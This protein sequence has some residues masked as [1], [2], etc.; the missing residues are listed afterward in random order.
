MP[1]PV[2]SRRELLARIGGHLVGV[3]VANVAAPVLDFFGT[4]PT[5]NVNTAV[6]G[7]HFGHAQAVKML[8]TERPCPGW[9]YI[10]C[11]C[12]CYA[13]ASMDA[14]DDERIAWSCWGGLQDELFQTGWAQ[15]YR[16][17]IH[18]LIIASIHRRHESLKDAEAEY[19]TVMK[20]IWGDEGERS[21]AGTK[22]R[23]ARGR[24]KYQELVDARHELHLL[25][26]AC[27]SAWQRSD[28]RD[29]A[30]GRK[31]GL[32]CPRGLD[33]EAR[34]AWC[35][36]WCESQGMRPDTPE[37]PGTDREWGPFHPLHP[38]PPWESCKHEEPLELAEITS[39][40]NEIEDASA[41]R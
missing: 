6:Q 37:G 17:T 20:F 32:L 3:H 27:E 7:F 10:H 30:L 14:P 23:L 31:G 35:R 39:Y 29:N 33:D 38:G 21:K 36:R 19:D 28:E 12:H 41:T 4:T 9:P 24:R 16:G 40:G 1:V 13:V 8:L 25:I 26:D 34:L 22:C 18:P 11:L 15:Y 2:I 5:W